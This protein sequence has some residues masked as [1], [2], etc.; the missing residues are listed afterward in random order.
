MPNVRSSSSGVTMAASTRLAPR[1]SRYRFRARIIA[2]PR[3]G[4]R[5]GRPHGRPARQLP[6]LVAARSADLAPIRGLRLAELRLRFRDGP[7]VP[8]LRL[9]L[10]LRELRPAA[11]GLGLA[12][13]PLLRLLRGLARFLLRGLACLLLAL[14]LGLR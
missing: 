13:G 5:A 7:G 9:G 10:L 4:H 6:R 2:A 8:L 1:S 3:A 12:L 14:G 11:V